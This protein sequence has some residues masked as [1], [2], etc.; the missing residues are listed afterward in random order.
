MNLFQAGRIIA[1]VV[2]AVALSFIAP[3]V[4]AHHHHHN[5]HEPAPDPVVTC[6]SHNGAFFY[7]ATPEVYELSNQ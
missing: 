4:F 7:V 2:P 1:F 3:G 5:D 6:D